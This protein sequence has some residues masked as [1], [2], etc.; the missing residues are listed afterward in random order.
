MW[1]FL[2]ILMPG[3]QIR[4]I[5]SESFFVKTK[6]KTQTGSKYLQKIHL[7]WDWYLQ[8]L[9]QLSNKEKTQFFKWA[10]D[11]NSTLPKI[12]YGWQF[13]T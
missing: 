11:L 12:L 13:N 2:K 8:S 7:I 4:A 10:K 1:E 5:T 3:P 9:S 6:G